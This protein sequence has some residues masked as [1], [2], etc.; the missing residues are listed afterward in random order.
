MLF[1]RAD[2]LPPRPS[3]L[4]QPCASSAP[5]HTTLHAHNGDRHAATG[6]SSA[7]TFAAALASTA[8]HRAVHSA[9]C[10][11]CTAGYACFSMPHSRTRRSFF[12]ERLHC[13]LSLSLSPTLPLHAYLP[14]CLTH[15]GGLLELPP[16][17]HVLFPLVELE[18]ARPVAATHAS[19]RVSIRYRPRR[20]RG[21]QCIRLMQSYELVAAAIA[22][23]LPACSGAG[24]FEA[25]ARASRRQPA[26]I[27]HTSAQPPA[28]TS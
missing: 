24:H 15:M 6:K 12:E 10:A 23:A 21:A 18:P 1:P 17:E 9:F 8:S 27:A 4:P 2:C 25:R 5:R 13:S 22:A 7:R 3:Q 20:R 19:R 28:I 16:P 11:P 14:A 26:A